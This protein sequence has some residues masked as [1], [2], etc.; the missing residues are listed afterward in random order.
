MYNQIYTT[1]YICNFL[2]FVSIIIF[3]FVVCFY[4]CICMIM[5]KCNVY[6]QFSSLLQR[7]KSTPKIILKI[8]IYFHFCFFVQTIPKIIIT[9][10]RPVTPSLVLI[11]NFSTNLFSQSKAISNPST[12]FIL[13]LPYCIHHSTFPHIHTTTFLLPPNSR[14]SST[15]SLLLLFK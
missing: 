2:S 3:V 5:S 1:F 9:I 14:Y 15:S 12:F 6:F 11:F 4:I 13:L 10:Y 8:K 7:L